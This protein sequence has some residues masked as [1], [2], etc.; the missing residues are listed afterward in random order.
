[1]LKKKWGRERYYNKYYNEYK[2]LYIALIKSY[3]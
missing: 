2:A 1:M 3:I